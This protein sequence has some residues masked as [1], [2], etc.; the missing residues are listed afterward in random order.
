RAHGG[1][2]WRDRLRPHADVPAQRRG[3]AGLPAG[4]HGF[5]LLHRAAA[6][7]RPAPGLSG[8]GLRYRGSR[9]RQRSADPA[10]A[11][12]RRPEEIPRRA[13]RRLYRVEGFFRTKK[14]S[15]PTAPRPDARPGVADRADQAVRRIVLDPRADP[16][17]QADGEP[18]RV[19]RRRLCPG[20]RPAA[21]ARA[22]RRARALLG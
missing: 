7:G 2:P 3:P 14:N 8:A 6:P 19:R 13:D 18:G 1:A 12:Y 4:L 16:R 5:A 9:A 17:A 22:A 11:L 21:R 15:L 10:L 20:A